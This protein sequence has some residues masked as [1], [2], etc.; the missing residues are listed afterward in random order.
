MPIG[1]RRSGHDRRNNKRFSV[2]IETEWEGLVGR[3]P[4]IISD[5]NAQGCFVL[6]SGDVEN[7]ENVKVFFPLTDG[8]KIQFWG[9]VV[10]HVFEIGFAMRFIELSN[11]QKDFLEKYI[12]TLRED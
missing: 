6:C 2:K 7:G 12:D 10:N 11:A 5:I 4:G 1:D 8:R 9:E 3:K